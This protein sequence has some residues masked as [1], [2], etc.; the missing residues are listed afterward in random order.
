M[1]D[2]TRRVMIRDLLAFASSRGVS[3]SATHMPPGKLGSYNSE[4]RWIYFDI[5]L[6]PAERRVTI[7]H[8][9]GHDFYNDSCS[10]RDERARAYAASLL[11][12]PTEYARLEQMGYD[13]DDKA[14][15]LL[16]TVECLRDFESMCLRPIG[17]KTYV[18]TPRSRERRVH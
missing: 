1:T 5:G 9:L 18:K 13:E 10:D 15:E 17:Q 7:A 6:T 16:V 4:T 14:D 3:I 12:D 2:A 8:E 11:I